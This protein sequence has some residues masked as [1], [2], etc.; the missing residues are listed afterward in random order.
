MRAGARKPGV[1]GQS[2][3]PVGARRD[4]ALSHPAI[5]LLHLQQ[6]AGNQA[7]RELLVQR[8][9]T[10]R[11]RD[12]AVDEATRFGRPGAGTGSAGLLAV[13]RWGEREHKETGDLGSGGRRYGFDTGG[14][15]ANDRITE[16]TG[17][18][19]PKYTGF[20]QPVVWPHEFQLTHGDL[21]MLGDWFELDDAKTHTD[22]NGVKFSDALF[23]LAQQPS[24]RPGQLVGTRDEIIY[25]IYKNKP[26]DPRFAYGGGSPLTGMWTTAV[27]NFSPAVK[28]RVENRYLRLAARNEQHFPTPHHPGPTGSSYREL[29]EDA[30]WRAYEAGR[31]GD[32][33]GE[34]LAR[35]GAAQ[36]FLVDYFSAGHIRTPIGDVRDYWS[37]RYPAFFDQLK[38]RIAY[39]VAEYINDNETGLATILGT[40][41]HIYGDVRA[42]VD[43]KT[44]DMP[45]FTFGDLVGRVG[46][47]LDNA[48]GV[49]VIND[50]GD[51]WL[52]YGDSH[53]HAAAPPLKENRTP[54]LA[55]LAVRLG[56]E[57]VEHA[58]RLG[59]TQRFS[60]V[61]RAT[62]LA[63]IKAAA[64]RPPLVGTKYAPEQI[65]PRLDPAVDNGKPGWQA[66][67]VLTL[68]SRLVRSD[69]PITYGAAI[70]D[71]LN[72][73]EVG[74]QLDDLARQFPEVQK[75]M[76]M[77]IH[78]RAAY[79]NG[80]LNPLKSNP[81][82]GLL[83]I[84]QF[85]PP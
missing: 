85:T 4:S 49:W 17:G 24:D 15:G 16:S 14:F 36:H 38:G 50:R 71:N 6:A 80:F 20:G 48:Q 84:I 64:A 5:G 53:L 19:G 76:D 13:Q 33:V 66:A 43:A 41:A 75:A 61:A 10:V 56:N 62:L 21:N 78:P 47:D 11:A 67:D 52:T 54:E 18:P 44:A 1:T 9:D 8:D 60:G 81:L 55:Q 27:G 57:E 73:G 59:T 65:M 29:H 7:V 69:K 72:N 22:A 3:S 39:A 83:R 34:G 30:L 77:W 12:A 63:E 51:R 42:T 25:A 31:A 32:D 74:S 2:A 23:V 68:W 58:Y 40:V 70:M 35:E 45:E 37:R 28:E 79:V 82:Y 26:D 46:H